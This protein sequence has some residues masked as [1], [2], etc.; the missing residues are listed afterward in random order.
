MPLPTGRTCSVCSA[1][2]HVL[3]FLIELKTLS[4]QHSQKSST[5]AHQHHVISKSNSYKSSTPNSIS[6]SRTGSTPTGLTDSYHPQTPRE[7]SDR[8][9]THLYLTLYLLAKLEIPSDENSKFEEF[10]ATTE[11]LF[12]HRTHHLALLK[13]FD[14]LFLSFNCLLVISISSFLPLCQSKFES[15]CCEILKY[16]ESTPF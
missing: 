14:L 7:V 5:S 8:Y 1:T 4:P 15:S 6:S 16:S 11:R 9:F 3:C 13:V 12:P 2:V 10:I